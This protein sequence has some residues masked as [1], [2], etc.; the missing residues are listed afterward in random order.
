L[1]LARWIASKDNPLT[2]RV[3]INRIWQ[4]H[5][6]TG[7][8][9]TPNNF[10]K[11]GARPTNPEL[12]DYLAGSFMDNGWSIK[13][14]HRL[15]LTSSTYQRADFPPRRL[16][17]EEI[18]DA[19][20]LASGELNDEMGGPGVFPELNW[21]VAH[22][23][24]HIMGSVAPAYQPSAT[25]RQRNRR[26]IYAFRYRTL[27]DPMLEVLNRPGSEL[28]CERRD[29]T[30]VT[31]QA[32]ALFNSAFAHQRALAMAADLRKQHPNLKSQISDAFRRIYARDATADELQRASAHV[33]R[34]LDHHRAHIPTATTLPSKVS[35][36][37][38]EEMTGEDVAWDESLD[39]MSYYQRD[40]TPADADPETRALAE[41][42]LVLLNSNEFLYVR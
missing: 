17:A 5:F 4:Q 37:M 39:G 18:R 34:M 10:G 19:M 41:L 31:P 36:H 16:A 28:S 9:A 3:I 8:V 7:L 33:A 12:L 1:A 38:V 14:L 15:I 32:F 13:K 40:L 35:R 25:P 26:T 23:P 29:E 11:M 20:L 21:E 30:T 6:G 2:A 27:A 22:Q 24:R 42:C